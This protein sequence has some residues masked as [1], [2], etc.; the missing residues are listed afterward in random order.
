MKLGE[1]ATAHTAI[2]KAIEIESNLAKQNMLRSDTANILISKNQIIISVEY[3]N[4]KSAEMDI[5]RHYFVLM[6]HVYTVR[7]EITH[8]IIVPRPKIN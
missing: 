1:Q 2:Q 8:R 4:A 6:H 3:L 5:T 7:I